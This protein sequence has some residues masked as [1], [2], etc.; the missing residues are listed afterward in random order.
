MTA[1]LQLQQY[2]LN[3][4]TVKG[5]LV[6]GTTQ[7]GQFDDRASNFYESLCNLGALLLERGKAAAVRCPTLALHN[8][9]L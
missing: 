1:G 9:G 4:G 7:P 6:H 2:E 8:D 5:H 3:P